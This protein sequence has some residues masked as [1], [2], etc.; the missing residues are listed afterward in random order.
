MGICVSTPMRILRLQA[1][2]Q[3]LKLGTHARFPDSLFGVIGHA[4]RI[5]GCNRRIFVVQAAQLPERKQPLHVR[6]AVPQFRPSRF[7]LFLGTER[8]RRLKN[9]RGKFTRKPHPRAQRGQH[10]AWTAHQ[11]TAF[12]EY[13][14]AKT[15]AFVNIFVR[16]DDAQNAPDLRLF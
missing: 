9:I 6:Q 10:F 8:F 1:A 14:S 5:A 3:P 4:H 16:P 2:L 15:L 11:S 12:S 13:R 7:Q